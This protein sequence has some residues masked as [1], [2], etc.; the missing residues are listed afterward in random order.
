MDR[1]FCFIQWQKKWAQDWDIIKYCS[2][3]CRGHQPG[4]GDAAKQ[5]SRSAH[6]LESLSSPPAI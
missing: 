5:A 4:S 3:T 2:D 6:R 1:L